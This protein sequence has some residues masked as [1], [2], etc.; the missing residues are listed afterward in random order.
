MYR[1]F[2]I[3]ETK[4]ER[5]ITTNHQFRTKESDLLTRDAFL[6]VRTFSEGNGMAFTAHCEYIYYQQT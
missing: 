6:E 2:Y 4:K 3:F 5:T 1:L